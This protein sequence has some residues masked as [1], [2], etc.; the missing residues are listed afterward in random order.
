LEGAFLVAFGD[1]VNA[2]CR[3][4]VGSVVRTAGQSCNSCVG[5]VTVLFIVGNKAWE[6]IG[7]KLKSGRADARLV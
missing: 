7:K 3:V 6:I 2:C 5:W 1:Q 4:D